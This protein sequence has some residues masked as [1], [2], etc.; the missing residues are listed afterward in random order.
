MDPDIWLRDCKEH[1]EC[2][3][4]HV[5]YLLIASKD[6]QG[7]VDTLTNNHHSKLKG[8]GPMSYHLGCDF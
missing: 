8:T 4:V 5:D 6:P 2:I 7:V 1:Y 3:A